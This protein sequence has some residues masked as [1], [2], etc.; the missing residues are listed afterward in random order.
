MMI[1]IRFLFTLIIIIL[2][3]G[4]AKAEPAK[5]NLS[6]AVGQM[7]MVG[8][9]GK[10]VDEHSPIIQAMKKYH[11]GGVIL[12]NHRDPVTR[13]ITTN[14]DNPAQLKKLISQLQFYAKK[15][16]AYPLLIATNQ[17]GGRVN[18]LKFSQG[19]NHK[20]DPSQFALGKK[21]QS[22][23]F[24]ETLKRARLLKEMGINVNLAPVADLNLNP[25][26]PG[27]GKLQRSFGSD[28]QKVT[29]D[30]KATIHAY[31]KANI[32]CTLKHFPGL[33]SANKNTDHDAADVT[34]T[35]MKRNSFH[36]SN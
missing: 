30:L 3:S 5:E 2:F 35:G 12:C 24:N 6:Y 14:I 16:H 8:F 18:T 36:I 4:M 1:R 11:I 28:P 9:R 34:E 7:M 15:Y 21:S 32:L 25:D 22:V 31:E 26:N 17:E 10:T 23:I 19:F 27:V 20:N 29:N 13:K 33:G